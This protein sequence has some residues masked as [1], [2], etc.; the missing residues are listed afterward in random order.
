MVLHITGQGVEMDYRIYIDD[1]DYTSKV[2]LPFTIQETVDESL[3]QAS[4]RLTQLASQTPFK[5]LTKVQ[6]DILDNEGIAFNSFAF[7]V[8]NDTV[9]ETLGT[10]KFVHQLT[11]IEQTKWLERFTGITKCATNPLIHDYTA[12]P[13]DVTMT[14]I[15]SDLNGANASY[16]Y[17]IWHGYPYIQSPVKPGKRRYP[18]APEMFSDIQDKLAYSGDI[19]DYGQKTE[20]YVNDDLKYETEGGVLEITHKK[21][22]NYKFVYEFQYSS[23]AIM[24]N[25]LVKVI[26]NVSCLPENSEHEDYTITRV[27]NE[28][29][30]TVETITDKQTPRF[31]FDT[32][33]AEK[34]S[35]IPSPEFNLNGTLYEC[36]K[37][38]GDYLQAIPR[39]RGDTITFDEIVVG[40]QYKLK[41]N[42]IA[43]S[44]S[45][46]IE[47]FATILDSQVD[48][49]V[50]TDAV[51][52][53]SLIEP[54]DNAFKTLRTD[55]ATVQITTDNAFIET[56]EAIEQIIKVECGYLKNGT[57]VGD[58]TPFVYSDT[59]YNGMLSSTEDVYP[60]SKAYAIYYKQGQKNIYG[61]NFKLPN[62][63]HQV[64]EDF[65]IV[66][67]IKKITGK[68]V[69]TGDL[70]DLQFRV[71]YIPNTN[72]RVRQH[73]T[74]YD[75]TDKS[76]ALNFNQTAQKVSAENYGKAIRGA[77]A[78]L[79]N[80]ERTISYVLTK[81]GDVPKCGYECQDDYYISMVSLEFYGDFFKCNI[82]L[83]K[84]YNRKDRYISLNNNIRFYEVSEQ[85]AFD[86]PVYYEDMCIIGND[87][88]G[89]TLAEKSPMITETGLAELSDA[90]NNFVSNKITTVNSVS[91]NANKEQI[92][93]YFLPVTSLGIGN[94]LLM[95]WEYVDNFTAG[96]RASQ[97]GDTKLQKQQPYGDVHG[98]IKYLGFELGKLDFES[99]NSVTTAPLDYDRAVKL[100]NDLPK[101]STSFINGRDGVPY[102]STNRYNQNKQIVD[103]NLIVLDKD[104][105]EIIG[106]NYQLNFVTN[107][108]LIIGNEFAKTCPFATMGNAD[109][110]L[111]VWYSA[112]SE[113]IG[114]KVIS[115][116]ADKL[117]LS[118]A[119]EIGKVTANVVESATKSQ[120]KIA[121]ITAET[122]M[123][124]N[125]LGEDRGFV[126]AWAV[127]NGDKLIFGKNITTRQWPT[128]NLTMPFLTFK[129]II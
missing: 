99:I 23:K 76:S 55:V 34:Y 12:N 45:F 69:S 44:T 30:E 94:A 68:T 51:D 106:F 127:V 114:K 98:K 115:K 118:K 60:T 58:I 33:Q 89:D 80:P 85:Q 52:I 73:K 107:D 120:I 26:F 96:T 39:L 129:H 101:S 3:D 79:G 2:A 16:E 43:Q 31:K 67:I 57:F 9:T 124:N 93:K 7:F 122:L 78:K 97:E 71:T 108:G 50:N 10:N 36:L 37:Q 11:L 88:A 49:M 63:I 24:D 111:Y 22:K 86:R 110:K 61:L 81:Y 59:E 105:R 28:L 70:L 20:V 29:L 102:F 48:N 8:S 92:A 113:D 128:Q 112:Y 125:P 47:Q 84:N 82:S 19:E 123:A 5:P 25:K 104:N 90:F 41:D 95:H 54:S 65:A 75:E 53:G 62:P 42:Y 6:F 46:D 17:D 119:T 14:I 77:L 117:D 56:S 18:S 66:N 21:D 126:I 91:Y 38:V 83:S 109:Y 87:I 100:G 121:D 72:I 4:L 116:L 1:K 103:Q 32:A 27:V 74:D 13:V 40:Q 64:F 35:N 15:E